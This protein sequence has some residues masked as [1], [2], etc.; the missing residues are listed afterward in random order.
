MQLTCYINQPEA[1]RRGHNAYSTVKLEID[2]AELTPAEREE[3]AASFTSGE[4]RSARQAHYLPEPTLQGLREKLQDLVA[5]A[6]AEAAAAAAAA[7]E[8]QA[9]TLS[10][11]AEFD[12]GNPAE[13]VTI[14]YLGN[15]EF[16]DRDRYNVLRDDQKEIARAI[17]DR[18]RSER[19]AQKALEAA[20]IAANQEAYQAAKD[21][22]TEKIRQWTLANGSE[23]LRLRAEEGFAWRSLAE[24][25]WAD[26]MLTQVGI[27]QP[28]VPAMDGYGFDDHSDA[29]T[30]PTATEVKKLRV[31]REA[32]KTIPE[33][34]AEVELRTFTY[35]KELDKQHDGDPEKIVRTE[36]KV[37]VNGPARGEVRYYLP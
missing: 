15:N 14:S 11:Q 18:L 21:Q 16:G 28:A 23:T 31:F 17:C 33:M 22:A 27:T 29:C 24:Q 13:M 25:E 1:I 5:K 10:I 19:E 30:T 12:A 35:T 2:P 36:L 8:K 32:L 3:L 6:A 26:A 4:F 9:K 37:T 20:R 7:A 34:A